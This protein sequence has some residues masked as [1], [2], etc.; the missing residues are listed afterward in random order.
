MPKRIIRQREVSYICHVNSQNNAT[1][2][3]DFTRFE[4]KQAQKERMI[5]DQWA[6]WSFRWCWVEWFVE[7]M[8]ISDDYD[9]SIRGVFLATPSSTQMTNK[10][11]IVECLF[12][13]TTCNDLGD[14]GTMTITLVEEEIEKKKWRND[15]SSR[16]TYK[17]EL[18]MLKTKHWKWRSSLSPKCRNPKE[19]I[20]RRRRKPIRPHKWQRRKMSPIPFV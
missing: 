13:A 6:T 14:V 3:M 2:M 12:E 7:T 9:A 15:I 16:K 17:V 8:T 10:Q 1:N 5:G 11:K 4:V 20:I 18:Q 19:R